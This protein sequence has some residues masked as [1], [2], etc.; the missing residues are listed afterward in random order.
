MFAPPSRHCSPVTATHRRRRR[1]NEG[2]IL[3]TAVLSQGQKPNSSPGS[4]QRGEARACP[5]AGLGQPKAPQH[6][7]LGWGRLLKGNADFSQKN[8]N[9]WGLQAAPYL[10]AR[11]SAG[12]DAAR[13]PSQG[14]AAGLSPKMQRCKR[15]NASAGRHLERGR[16]LAGLFS[17]PLHS[18]FRKGHGFGCVSDRRRRGCLQGGLNPSSV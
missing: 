14:A 13:S 1:N 9:V 6:T 4:Q 7:V 15:G 12:G 10:G 16:L 11:P 5:W 3:I 18:F 8:N 17:P 2:G